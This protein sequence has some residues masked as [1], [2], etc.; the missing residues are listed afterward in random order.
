MFT[1][2]FDGCRPT[3]SGSGTVRINA[4]YLEDEI[5]HEDIILAEEEAKWVEAAWAEEEKRNR[6]KAEARRAA[7]EEV[8]RQLA[9]EAAGVKSSEQALHDTWDRDCACLAVEAFVF[10]SK[11]IDGK[12]AFGIFT[13]HEEVDLEA[14]EAAELASRRGDARAGDIAT[15]RQ[16]TCQA[17]PA[18][19]PDPAPLSQ[20]DVAFDDEAATPPPACPEAVATTTTPAPETSSQVTTAIQPPPACSGRPWRLWRRWL[21]APVTMRHCLFGGKRTTGPPAQLPA[22]CAQ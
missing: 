16:E 3:I 2:G 14:A 1:C 15:P 22:P 13:I 18:A 7:L 12:P 20:D 4:T 6:E 11:A 5:I 19:P 8:A 17:A 21:N 10:P 9:D